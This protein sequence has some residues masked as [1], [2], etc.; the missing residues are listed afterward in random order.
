[1]NIFDLRAKLCEGGG[2]VV[3]IPSI[4]TNDLSSN[5]AD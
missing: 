4:Y 3:R 2:Q 5:H 1:M